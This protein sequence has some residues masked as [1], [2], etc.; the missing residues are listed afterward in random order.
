M[1]HAAPAHV[2]RAMEADPVACLNDRIGRGVAIN[3]NGTEALGH[4]LSP[5][6]R[7]RESWQRLVPSRPRR[8]LHRVQ[9]PVGIFAIL[10]PQHG[11]TRPVRS[12]PSLTLRAGSGRPVRPGRR[13]RA[14]LIKW[15]TG[16]K[17]APLSASA[18]FRERGGTQS[19][20][21]S[22]DTSL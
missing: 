19:A 8:L 6:N 7:Q 13:T 17:I 20:H 9:S 12:S 5:P 10:V 1:T 4:C 21:G 11:A 22:E 15:P 2:L 3:I 18:L 16:E 14:L